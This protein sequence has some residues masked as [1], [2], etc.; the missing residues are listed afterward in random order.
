MIVLDRHL[1][2]HAEEIWHR[3]TFPEAVEIVGLDRQIGDGTGSRDGFTA[4]VG[5][6]DIREAWRMRR[7]LGEQLVA[8][9]VVVGFY[10]S[11][12]QRRR[13]EPSANN[14]HAQSTARP[15]SAGLDAADAERRRRWGRWSDRRSARWNANDRRHNEERTRF[16]HT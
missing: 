7:Q 12:R 9:A 5:Q 13:S 14:R 3:T 4:R 15:S 16:D 11:D 2:G 10:T 8:D 1:E 6:R